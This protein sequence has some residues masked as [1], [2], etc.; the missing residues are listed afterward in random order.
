MK[1]TLIAVVVLLAVIGGIALLPHNSG[2]KNIKIGMILPL[3]G[4]YGAL[5]ENV[6][7]GAQLARDEYVKA[8][9]GA[10]VQIIA[11]DDVLD[12]AKG[13]TAY[14]KLTDLDHVQA[15]IPASGPTLG[16]IY[17]DAKANNIPM[18]TVSSESKTESADNVFQIRP[19]TESIEVGLGAYLKEH[20]SGKIVIVRT[21]DQL[22]QKFSEKFMSGYGSNIETFITNRG[23]KDFRTIAAKIL[24]EKPD[25]IVTSNY[26]EDG[27]QLLKAILNM[28]RT[29]SRPLFV[30]DPVFNE[31][32]SD[33]KKVLGDMNVLN[34]S[35]VASIQ[36]DDSENFIS[37]YK[38]KYGEAPG[39]LADLGYDAFKVMMNSYNSDKTTWIKNLAATDNLPGASGNITFDSLGLRN[40][41]FEIGTL[42]D[43]KIPAYK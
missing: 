2:V 30:F 34:G 7:K 38:A 6:V 40:S 18:V 22:T 3:T 21:N 36:S 23:D 25:V 8:H 1:K 31:S 5:G 17:D 11:E 13:L 26:A 43:G 20:T 42:Q 10:D 41:R 29:G 4:E 24:A 32:F 28:T 12:A 15:I 33:Y 14:K 16:A 27:T 9:L 37:A 39:Q 19:S 35:V